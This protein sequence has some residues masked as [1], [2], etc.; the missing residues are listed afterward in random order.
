[1]ENEK[2]EEFPKSKR[3]YIIHLLY[4]FSIILSSFMNWFTF[5]FI[6]RKTFEIYVSSNDNGS[7]SINLNNYYKILDNLDN[8][9]KTNQNIDKFLTLDL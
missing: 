7:K 2:G 5:Y 4:L 9:D 8:R 3:T 6:V 1:M